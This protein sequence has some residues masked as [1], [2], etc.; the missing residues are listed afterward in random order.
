M[1]TEATGPLHALFDEVWRQ[2]LADRPETATYVGADGDHGRWTD[3]SLD[4]WE[5]RRREAAEPLRRLRA[6]DRTA[7]SEADQLS[8]D[9]FEWTME[10]RADAAAFPSHLMPVSQMGGPQQRVAS[11]LAM[12]RAPEDV[13]ARL[14]A[15]PELVDQTIELLRAGA[16]SGVTP[17]AITL[18]D[19]PA[20]I[21]ALL[22]D[23]P[24]QSPLLAALNEELQAEAA[25]IVSA[26]VNPA[27]WRLRAHVVDSYLPDA[28]TDIACSSLPDGAAWYA[29]LVRTHTTTELTPQEIHELGRQE[30][31]RIRAAM[32]EVIAE[33]GFDG[34][35]A[36]FCHH[37]RTDPR[38]FCRSA[39]ELLARYREIC[40]RIDPGLATLFGTLP[41]LPY[42]VCAV[43]S[44][45]E[46]SQTT[47][48]YQPGAPDVGRPGWY[49][50][51]T[52]DLPSRPIWEMEALSLHEA[53]PGHHLQISLAQELDVP[54]FRRQW[55]AFT[56]YVEGWG[57]YAE[58]LGSDLG[59]YQDPYSRFGQLTYE[60]WRA[61]RL[62]VDT[63]MH[64]L[65]WT[66]DEAIT[67]FVDQA[68]KAEHDIVVETDR[69]IV[70]PGQA[71]AYKLGEL[72][73][74]R[75]RR[76][77]EAARGADFDIR[78][79]HDAVLLDGPLPLSLL[80]E[81]VRG[82]VSGQR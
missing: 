44:H 59:L 25:T 9:L 51:N 12:T 66:R 40:K 19:I 29:H 46:R 37:L 36:E 81:R 20:Q 52:Y 48:Y 50:A 78:A 73:L 7:L 58:S 31:A 2:D 34:G 53:V 21:D 45:A 11:V 26:E 67:Y 79:F 39:D 72:T 1:E 16:A 68:S 55:S 41:R 27:F 80:E 10:A 54:E 32:D 74:Q 6:I 17:P 77:A 65:G 71:L 15:V 18:R 75:L 82:T 60:M 49:F 23:D 76:E 33:I 38:F 61:V 47:A 64:A 56:A 22:V 70:W 4:A 14:R 57:L 30:V 69:Y 13:L 24:E 62:V 35:F 43:P 5:R 63:G 28:R 8:Y 42:G 3:H